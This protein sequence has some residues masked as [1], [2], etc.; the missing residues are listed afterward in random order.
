MITTRR[1]IR[2]LVLVSLG[3]AALALKFSLPNRSE[4]GQ[5]QLPPETIA[6]FQRDL[7]SQQSVHNKLAQ[8]ALELE[9]TE[10]EL[11]QTVWAPEMEAERFEEFF[12]QLWDNIN[13]ADD[14]WAVLKSC[15]SFAISMPEGGAAQPLPHGIKQ[16][17]FDGAATNLTAGAWR[18][19]FSDLDRAG[20]RLAN[21]EARHEE[22]HSAAPGRDAQSMFRLTANLVAPSPEKR[23]SFHADLHVY[24][25]KSESPDSVAPPRLIEVTNAV[26]LEREGLTPFEELPFVTI[27]PRQGDNF[28][29]PLIVYDL[30]GDGFPEIIFPACNLVY[31]RD[32][33]NTYHSETLCATDPGVIFSALIADFDRDGTP[34]LLCA[35]KKGLLLF[36]GDQRGRFT[37]PPRRVWENKLPFTQ[38]M[39][40]ADVDGD[41]TLDVWLGQYRNPYEAGKMPTPYYDANDG[42]PS[43]LLLNDGR[44]NFH[45]A[46]E[47]S[48]LAAK[49]WRSVYS[50]SLA[51][52]NGDGIPDL[53]KVSDF[54][55]VDIF[56]NDGKGHFHEATDALLPERHLFG[57][58]HVIADL[59]SDG[60]PDLLAIGM[61]SPTADRLEHL[62]LARPGVPQDAHFRKLMTYGNRLYLGSSNGFLAAP[63]N[64][65]LAKTGWS[66]GATALDADNDGHQDVYIVNGHRTNKSVREYEPQFWRH[67]IYLGQLTNKPVVDTYYKMISAKISGHGASYGGYEKKRFFLNRSGKGFL[68]TGF[69]FGLAFEQDGRNAV[70]ADLD[71]DGRMDLLATTVEVWP[72]KR[73]TLRIF[74]NRWATKNHW[75]G[76]HLREEG[77]GLTPIGAKVLIRTPTRL[78]IRYLITGDSHRSQQP[79][80]AHFGLGAETTVAEAEV[81][82]PNGRHTLIPSPAIDRYHLVKP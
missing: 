18:A 58:A 2:L 29:D 39:T 46:T 27:T 52:L 30:D 3:T 66:W 20:F 17:S 71:G 62:G 72:E 16:T 34:D 12:I 44:G 13:A 55:G 76:F 5:K 31:R 9:R 77:A 42:F 14:K 24:W 53:L 40:A 47:S 81:I 21:V 37:K 82:W 70:S 35:D 26:L 59:N 60:I 36:E 6:T 49:R 63:Q 43:Y 10:N 68:E 11:D 48:G 32:A 15:P 33:T 7:E 1:K 73:Q 50:A 38:V 78:Q 57:M 69:L 28:I 80:T 41:G 8:D 67:D 79:N 19:A 45:D 25:A 23:L 22:F 54:A 51:D 75:I 4:L 61:N 74:R 65:D 56:L 64:D